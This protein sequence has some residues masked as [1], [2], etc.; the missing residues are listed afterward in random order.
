MNGTVKKSIA[1]AA[2]AAICACSAPNGGTSNSALP[3][4]PSTHRVTQRGHGVLST[5]V[6]VGDSL[7]AGYQAGG[8]LGAT[9]FKDPLDKSQFVRPGQEN[10][11]WADLDEMASGLPEATAIN[12]MYDPSTSPLPLIRAPALNN[13]LVPTA[14]GSLAPF[15]L[16]KSG[17]T[18]T[19]D[20]SFNAAGYVLNGLS[21]VRLN[22]TSSLVRDVAVPGITAH[23]AVT[24][25][26]PQNNTC[27]PIPGIP[28]LLAAVVDGEASTFWPVLGNFAHMGTNLTE[29]RAA[30]SLHPTLATVW[31]GANDVLKYMGS[32]GRFVGGDNSVAQMKADELDAI[33]TLKYAGAKTVVLDLP[34]VLRTPYFLNTTIPKM[35]TCKA[36]PM[37]TPVQTYV[38][39]VLVEPPPG[40]VGLFT[41]AQAKASIDEFAALYHITSPKECKPGTVATACGYLT[42][43]GALDSLN[44]YLANSDT[45]PD[46]DCTGPNFTKPCVPGSGLGSYYIT[47]A[48]AGKI[49][50]LNDNINTGIQEAATY[51]QSAFVDV[52]TIFDGILSGDS[53]NAYFAKAISIN[54]GKCCTLSSGGGLLSFD[55]LHPSNTGYALIAYY[56]IQAINQ[57]YGQHI[58]EI[59]VTK[60]YNGTRCSN[61]LECYP[62]A[63]AP[64]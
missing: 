48:F 43:P 28:G 36:S 59:D 30:A 31:L 22:P 5:I 4:T 39:C 42:L 6:G 10:G 33:Q 16:S 26:Q 53:A 46:L 18:C 34:D 63:Y 56:A 40:G 55:G 19:A 41:P 50:Q 3:S 52:R 58:H 49:Q 15:G 11:W 12:R 64:H 9:N 17:N 35:S 21:T 7:T 20:G 1:F 45:F 61:K 29:V 38:F 27:E 44:Y 32:G 13:L 2:L 47:P 24:I 57:R 37:H 14:P 62:D 51:T 23:E 8:F 54:P 25:S 60:A